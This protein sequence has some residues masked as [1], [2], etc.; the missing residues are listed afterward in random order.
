M[1]KKIILAV[2]V[3]AIIGVCTGVYMWNKKPPKAEDS[4]GIVTSAIGITKEYTADEKKADAAY[5]NKVLELSGTVAEVTKNQDG[6]T[7]VNL[8]TGDP[9]A[10]AQCTMREPN[11]QVTKGQNIVIKGFCK[12]NNMG[13]VITDCILK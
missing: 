8:E 2:V 12:G 6:A 3:I 7:V 11:V 1:V 13:V 5:L 10:A 9:M 4:K